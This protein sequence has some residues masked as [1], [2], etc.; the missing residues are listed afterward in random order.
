MTTAALLRKA[1]PVNV[2]EAQ[3]RLSKLISSKMPS[4]VLSHGKPV[5]FLMP[6][7]EMLD[8]VEMLED[9][10]DQKLLKEIA[11]ART[12]YAQGKAIPVER[13]FRRMGL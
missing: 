12:E 8:L 4:L 9:L 13:M 5:S 6:Y 7:D 2:R 3:A 10:K 11:K 1:K